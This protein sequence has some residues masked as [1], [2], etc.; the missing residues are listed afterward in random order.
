MQFQTSVSGDVNGELHIRGKKLTDLIGSM[1]Y[2]SAVYFMLMGKQPSSAQTIMLNAIL[3]ACMDHGVAP[4]SGFVPRVVT[5]SGNG[6]TQ[7][8]AAGLL[9]IGPFHG[10]AVEGAMRVFS[11]F[12]QKTEEELTVYVR[13]QRAQKKRL[14]GYGHRKYTTEDPRT[15]KL[16]TLAHE[17]GI[18]GPYMSVARKLEG[19]LEVE[20]GR[21]LVLN[22]DGAV[23]ALLLELGLSPDAGNGIFALARIG[24]ML[25]HS[26]EEKQQGT[27]VRRLDDNEVVYEQ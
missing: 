14:P 3:V 23:A 12:Q 22:I 2:P 18:D 1:D 17:Q 20:L 15:E 8:L 16:F 27:I 11:A 24:G 19:A 6:I 21:K 5:A 10:G 13:D 9:A 4:A 26:L 25:A 7:S